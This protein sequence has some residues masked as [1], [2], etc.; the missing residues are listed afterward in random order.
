MWRMVVYAISG[1]GHLIVL[2]LLIR[3]MR[4][5]RKKRKTAEF[6]IDELKKVED[7][8]KSLNGFDNA[9]TVDER[10]QGEW[11]HICG[12]AMQKNDNRNTRR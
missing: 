7:K 2:V 5:T 8:P 10:L 4:K 6:L 12:K 3:E 11:Q 1:I 9:P